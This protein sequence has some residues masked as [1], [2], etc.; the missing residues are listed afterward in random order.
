[1]SLIGKWKLTT[2][3]NFDEYMKAI[4]KLQ[5]VVVF[6]IYRSRRNQLNASYLLLSLDTPNRWSRINRFRTYLVV[7]IACLSCV[8]LGARRS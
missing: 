4:G 2:Q 7:N 1:M 8:Y 6:V 5:N 3:E